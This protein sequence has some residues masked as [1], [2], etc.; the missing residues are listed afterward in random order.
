[1]GAVGTAVTGTEGEEA[2]TPSSLSIPK[3]ADELQN[4]I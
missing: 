2:E 1:M 4:L 3:N